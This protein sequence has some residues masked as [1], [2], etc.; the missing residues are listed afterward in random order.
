MQKIVLQKSKKHWKLICK[1][2]KKKNPVI[3]IPNNERKEEKPYDSDSVVH[4][5]STTMPHRAD[6]HSNTAID[7]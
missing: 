3:R 6:Y 1:S 7:Y 5:T 4:S 2:E